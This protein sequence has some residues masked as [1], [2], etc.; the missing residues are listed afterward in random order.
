MDEAL[1]TETDCGGL[2][3]V[4]SRGDIRCLTIS[5]R[6]PT[7]YSTHRGRAVAKTRITGR[8]QITIPK[9]VPE[10]LGLRPE[11][12]IEFVEGG[13]GFRVQKRVPASPLKR[14]RGYLKHLADRD[15]DELVEEMR[16][17]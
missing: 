11:G 14:Y 1:F 9:D 10:R 3:G 7:H 4:T 6:K 8:G 17:R 5:V 13:G 16:G 2:P 15:P 12:E